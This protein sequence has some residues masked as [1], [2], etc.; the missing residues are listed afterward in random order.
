MCLSVQLEDITYVI[1]TQDRRTAVISV[2]Y[3]Q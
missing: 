1:E 2:I 3:V